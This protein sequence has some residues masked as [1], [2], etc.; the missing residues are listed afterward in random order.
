MTETLKENTVENGQNIAPN[1]VELMKILAYL[2]IFV[3]V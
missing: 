3:G 2:D 1:T